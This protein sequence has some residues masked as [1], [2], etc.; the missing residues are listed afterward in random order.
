MEAAL[1][2]LSPR[3]RAVAELVPAGTAVADVG[4]DHAQLLAWLRRHGRITRGVGIDVVEGPLRQA[5]RTL[6]E[7]RVQGVELRHGDGLRPLR[8]GEV[9][10][11]VLA[12]MGGARMI[13]LLDAAPEVVEG[14][15]RLV[16]QPNTD[17]VAMRRWVMEHGR[18][19]DERMVEDRGKF[20]VVLGVEPGAPEATRWSEDELVLGPR[21]RRERPDPF[22][23]WLRHE[24]QRVER[25]LARAE[26]GRDDAAR[27][28]ELRE[29][30]A[31]VVA[32]LE[33]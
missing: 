16:L 18:L 12:G 27:V 20:Y 1:I 14:L 26:R 15:R 4:T 28:D 19:Q 13:R 24:R 5:E 6:S 10:V 22:V 11:V 23:A 9:E 29:H 30:R 31:R 32:E 17:W 21:L 2:R 3:L 25:A 8:A 7:A 33:R